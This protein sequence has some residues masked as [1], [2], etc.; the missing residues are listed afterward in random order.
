MHVAVGIPERVDGV[1]VVLRLARLEATHH[2][3]FAVDILQ[4]I[5]M[6]EQV[7]ERGVEDRTLL[8][9]PTLD[10]YDA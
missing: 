4:D 3:I 10:L 8:L 1:A 6:D 2:R 9:G 7:V 5:G